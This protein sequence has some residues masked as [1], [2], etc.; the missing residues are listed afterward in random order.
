MD[1]ETLRK[2]QLAQLEIA[3]E[4][5]RICDENQLQYFMDSGTLLG[6][7][8]HKGFIP[9]DDDMDFGMMRDQYEKFLSVAPDILGEKFFIQT[10][11]SDEN[12]PYAFCKIRKKDTV[13]RESVSQKSKMHHELYIDIFPYDVY[14]EESKE[15]RSQGKKIM[16]YKNSMMMKSALTP[17]LR[18]NSPI[19]R[20]LVWM[21]WL[22][23]RIYAS[24]N[25]RQR[26]LKKYDLIMR[27]YNHTDSAFVYE[28]TGGTPYGKWVLDRVCFHKY[29]SLPFED[30]EFLAPGDYKLYL[31]TIYGDYMKLPPKEQRGNWHKILEVKL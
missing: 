21:K 15:Q 5:K 24:F 31:Q 12:Y 8:R 3:K 16:L 10:W 1:K 9:W 19:Q 13:Y 23:Y 27:K 26:I 28:Q 2:V 6:A 25:A 29:I 14:P 18:H 22:P 20:I 4:F 11:S 30:T 7:V 17:W